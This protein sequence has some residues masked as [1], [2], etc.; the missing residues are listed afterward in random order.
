M[1]I[2]EAEKLRKLIL[3]EYEK[4]I[5]NLENGTEVEVETKNSIKITKNM[6]LDKQIKGVE[7]NTLKRSDSIYFGNDF[8]NL[9]AIGV[10]NNAIVMNQSDY[11]KSRRKTVSNTHYSRHAIKSKFFKN[12]PQNTKNSVIFINRGN[13]QLTVITDQPMK[14]TKD[15]VSF[16]VLKPTKTSERIRFYAMHELGH[17]VLHKIKVNK[18]KS[19]ATK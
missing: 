11:R 4:A 15:E 8:D 12:L 14:D 17:L 18:Y 9:Q 2:K 16:V 7:E 19:I 1:E 5:K 6:P 3:S 10:S 13:K